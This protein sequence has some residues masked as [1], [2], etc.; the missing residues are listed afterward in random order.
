MTGVR[1][2]LAR[3]SDPG[4]SHAAAASVDVRGQHGA[5]LRAIAYLVEATSSE[6]AAASGLTEHQTSRRLSELAQDRR[7]VWTGRTRP[8]VS[9]RAQRVWTMYGAPVQSELWADPS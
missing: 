1:H 4:T 6:I 9:G 3:R 7:I 2:G 8:G 5:C